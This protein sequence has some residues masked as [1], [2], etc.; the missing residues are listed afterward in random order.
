MAQ[1]DPALARLMAMLPDCAGRL[2]AVA[3]WDD[4]GRDDAEPGDRVGL[5]L[6]AIPTLFVCLRGAARVV[7]SGRRRIDLGAGEAVV[8]APGIRHAHADP[9]GDSVGL[10]LG[11]LAG[12]CDFDLSDRANRLWCRVPA[13]PYQGWCDRLLRDDAGGRLRT[14]RH[15]LAALAEERVQS[16][17]FPHPAQRAMAERLWSNRAGLDATGILAAS[18]LSPRRAH[19]LFR[20][21]FGT[22]PK[23]ALIE[24][25][26]A[27]A[28]RHLAAGRPVGEAARLVGFRRRADLTRAWRAHHGAPPSARGDLRAEDPRAS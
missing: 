22:T 17:G 1:F 12:V 27:L 9:R 13:E 20:A 14:T 28:R 23:R 18:G 5:H 4:D 15:L 26:L 19:A 16:M 2:T 3:R 6:H 24:Q 21:F 10:D 8:I 7:G 11:F 25:R